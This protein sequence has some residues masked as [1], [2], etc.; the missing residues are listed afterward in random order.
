MSKSAQ[1]MR[2]IERG[3]A[4]P[5]HAHWIVRRIESVW[6][7]EA[8]LVTFRNKFVYLQTENKDIFFEKLSF[9]TH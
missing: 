8:V 2:E 9:S 6:H 7:E 4:E 5:L 3:S 1:T